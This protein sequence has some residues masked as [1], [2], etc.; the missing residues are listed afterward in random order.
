MLTKF[1]LDKEFDGRSCLVNEPKTQ[2]HNYDVTPAKYAQ[3]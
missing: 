1:S 2:K 3:V